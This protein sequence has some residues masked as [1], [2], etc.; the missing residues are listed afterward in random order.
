MIAANKRVALSFGVGSGKTLIGL[1]GYTHLHQQGKVKRGL[2]LVPSIVQGQFGGD[3]LKFL[4]PGTFNWHAEPGASRAERI[5]A[6]KNPAHNFAVM[7]HQAFRDD[8][9][10]LGAQQAGVSPEA[11]GAKLEA[12]TRP[13]R[14][15]W[16]KGVM[17]GEGIDFDYLNV[18]EGHNTLNRKGKENSALAN[19]VDAMS[20]NTPYYVNASGDPIKNDVS[21]A[22]SLLQKMDPER[23]TDEGAFTRKYG[24]D[25]LAAKDELRRELARFQYPSKI[26]PDVVATKSERTVGLSD[27]Q[28]AALRSVDE[29][30]A[31]VRMARMQGKVDVEAMK[32][33]S[34]ASFKGAEDPEAVAREMQRDIG[35]LKT[36][37]IKRILDA[38]PDSAKLDEVVK[39]ARERQGKPGLVFAHSLPAVDLVKD[40]LEKEGFRVVAIT[41][42]DSAADKEAKRRQFNDGGEGAPDVLVASDAGATGMNAQRGQYAVQFDTPQTAM[43]HAQRQGRINRTGQKNDVELIDLVTDHPEERRA[44]ERLKLKYALR[45]ALTTPMESLDDTGVAY[46]LNRAKGNP[47]NSIAA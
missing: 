22:F 46:Y 42:K 34:P 14:K 19:V 43:T 40:R 20:D 10:H 45:D 11:M 2:F 24:V 6:Y 44:R 15:A 37:A 36:A 9:I 21:E 16:L 5:A 23:Y 27:K 32:V 28:R 26:D 39:V 18:D 7:T 3:A 41:G 4:K 8:M 29:N 33:L 12:M 35:L 38:S 13:E 30:L 25:T 31:R 17:A 1:S 47:E